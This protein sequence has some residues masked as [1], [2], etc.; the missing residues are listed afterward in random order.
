MIVEDIQCNQDGV[1]TTQIS[2]QTSIPITHEEVRSRVFISSVVKHYTLGTEAHM[3]DMN[4]SEITLRLF[5][6]PTGSLP[7]FL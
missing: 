5:I 6:F 1:E 4:V 7:Q 2:I 3:N